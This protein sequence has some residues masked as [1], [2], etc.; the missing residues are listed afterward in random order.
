MAGQFPR[1]IGS[2]AHVVALL[3]SG[4]SVGVPVDPASADDCL[5]API[6]PRRRGATAFTHW[7]GQIRPKCW[8]LPGWL[9][10]HR[11]LRQSHW[12]QPHHR[13]RRRRS[14]ARMAAGQISHCSD[15]NNSR[16]QCPRA[17]HQ[18]SGRQ[19][20]ACAGR[21]RNNGRTCPTRPA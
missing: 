8:R 20:K 18:N 11:R 19:P 7:I 10:A 13:T 17:T 5:K 16:R 12:R 3:V 2:V 1:P 14:L 4:L 6:L 9:A 15:V 21:R